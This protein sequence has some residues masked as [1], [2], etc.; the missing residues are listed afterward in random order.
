MREGLGGGYQDLQIGI[1]VQFALFGRAGIRAVHA[2][3]PARNQI[4]AN[5]HVD[6][7]CVI[8]SSAFALANA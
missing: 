6:L 7:S 1:A 8:G 2:S 5:V 3:P 4:C